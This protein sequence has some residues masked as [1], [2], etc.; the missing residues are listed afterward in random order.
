MS[1]SR[2][3]FYN[4]LAQSLGKIIAVFVIGLASI[5]LLTSYLAERGFGQY[6]T[7]LA[8]LGIVASLADLGLYIWLVREI[9]T[10]GNSND[11]IIS[12]VLGLR[13]VTATGFLL[14]GAGVAILLPYEAEVKR[15]MFVA[16]AAFLFVSVNQVLIGI[17]QKHLAQYLVTAAEVIGRLINLILIYLFVR[18]H[19]GLSAFMV[20][21]IVGNACQFLL[22]LILARRYERFGIGFDFTLWKRILRASWPLAFSV[23]LNL[24]YFKADTVILSLVSTPEA[25]G[26]YSLPYKILEI[27]L[28]FPAM[29]AGLVMPLLSNTAF[30]DWARFKT[31][32]QKSFDA[33][34]LLALPIITTTLFFA[35]DIINLVNGRETGF[36]D[37]AA[38]L[39]I[40]IAAA[41][42]IFL[43]TLFGYAVTAIRREKIM[44][45]GY[46]L[47]AM[48]GLA[49]Y[50]LTIP[51]FGYYGAAWS[52][53]AIEAFVAVFAYLLVRK[54]LE[55]GVSL[56]IVLQSLPALCAIIL[57]FHLVS[58]FW[59]IEILIGLA[60]YAA[61]LIT[62]K[63]V[64][65]KF[66]QELVFL[67]K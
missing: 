29:F 36:E 44:V 45:Y 35:G 48:L 57:F 28:A 60:L 64:P 33:M 16:V 13:L 11:K 32:L 38:V 31:I 6:N 27:L 43:G 10:S 56:K 63:A 3:I 26:V 66:I 53:V 8:F 23:V 18:Q 24:V 20:A 61:L 41:G 39:Q 40:L 17:F 22:T 55:N 67:K 5:N 9:S 25:V 52:T 47:T 34:V 7:V 1:L 14:L 37:S 42:I 54:N 65:T 49:L 58:F 62:F 59:I 15:A 21:L 2:S 4:T 19:L 50:L 51:R 12:N 30:T 46:L